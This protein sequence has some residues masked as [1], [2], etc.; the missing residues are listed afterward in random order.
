MSKIFFFRAQTARFCFSVHPSKF[1]AGYATAT[2]PTINSNA[3]VYV[4]SPLQVPD[5]SSWPP[6]LSHLPP[7][8]GL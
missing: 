8:L 6:A 5:S 2:C 7:H 1:G 3:V 4:S